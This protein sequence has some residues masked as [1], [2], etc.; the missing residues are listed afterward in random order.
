MTYINSN[1]V[2]SASLSSL[3][4]EK[5]GKLKL[6]SMFMELLQT[7]NTVLNTF[8]KDS[9]ALDVASFKVKTADLRNMPE[10][11]KFPNYRVEVSLK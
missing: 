1:S 5:V 3:C 9:L 10:Q 6:D 7:R 4:I 8:M 2:E 11:L